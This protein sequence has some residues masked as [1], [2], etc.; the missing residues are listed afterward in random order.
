MVLSFYFHVV[1]V[2]IY[3]QLLYRF[4]RKAHEAAVNLQKKDIS[5]CFQSICKLAQPLWWNCVSCHL[6]VLA[7][8]ERRT[9]LSWPKSKFAHLD[10][11]LAP[12]PPFLFCRQTLG[13][14]K[15]TSLRQLSHCQFPDEGK[16]GPL[17]SVPRSR[18]TLC[19]NNWWASRWSGLRDSED[20]KL[21][22][23]PFCRKQ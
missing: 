20:Y 19:W 23:R 8:S 10:C 5:S 4:S 21:K 13:V 17:H 12:N 7:E 9:I 3:I 14:V 2:I 15:K 1:I 18:P 16:L 6:P 22:V 11:D